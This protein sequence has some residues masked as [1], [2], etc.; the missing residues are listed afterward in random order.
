MCSDTT[1][2]SE[3]SA[4]PRTSSASEIS[5]KTD[6]G[7]PLDAR[8]AGCV[9]SFDIPNQ[10]KCD[11]DKQ[12][13]H[14]YQTQPVGYLL[15]GSH[16]CEQNHQPDANAT[17]DHSRTQLGLRRPR[18]PV[19]RLPRHRCLQQF[20][21]HRLATLQLQS[22]SLVQIVVSPDPLCVP[23]TNGNDRNTERK[24]RDYKGCDARACAGSMILTC[25]RRWYRQPCA[26]VRRH[27]LTIYPTLPLPHR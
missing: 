27:S 26:A 6:T 14:A 24:N 12:R 7:D 8:L 23:Y 18:G 9:S 17:I 3:S 4:T 22:D 1:G 5:G 25:W 20:F 2:R 16:R 10:N 11:A 21:G 19:R 13:N 15:V